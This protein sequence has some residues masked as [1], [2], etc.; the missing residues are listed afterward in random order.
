MF[1]KEG[2]KKTVEYFFTWLPNKQLARKALKEK[3]I[4]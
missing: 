3:T 1:Q 4:F 2:E